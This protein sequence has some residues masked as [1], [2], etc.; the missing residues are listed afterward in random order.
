MR[1]IDEL[2]SLRGVAALLIAIYHTP[3]WTGA[4]ELQFLKNGH[5]MV[6][7][8]FVL[9]GFVIH[10]NYADSSQARQT[11]SVSSF[12]VLAGCIRFICSF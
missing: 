2:E 8:F 6:P 9:S 4:A 1:K 3:H 7:L 10:A 5:L 11:S 12:F